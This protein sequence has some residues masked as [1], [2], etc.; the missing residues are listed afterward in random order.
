MPNCEDFINKLLK[1]SPNLTDKEIIA[2]MKELKDDKGKRLYK[3]STIA[4]RLRQLRVEQ[5][6]P[7]KPPEIEKTDED[8]IIDA[9]KFDAPELKNVILD[10]AKKEVE[11]AF[12]KKKE[13]NDEVKKIELQELNSGH[14]KYDGRI[15]PIRQ[16]ID[17][18]I[19]NTGKIPIQQ[20]ATSD[21]IPKD[22]ISDRLDTIIKRIDA[23]DKE[24][25][26]LKQG[27]LPIEDKLVDIQLLESIIDKLDN[28]KAEESQDINETIGHLIERNNEIK[29]MPP[30]FLRKI[31]LDKDGSAH[32]K[33]FMHNGNWK[34]LK[35][36]KPIIYGIAGAVV[37]GL[38]LFALLILLKALGVLPGWI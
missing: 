2:K 35:R 34:F 14:K 36:A 11:D 23:V 32:G 8:V 31:S 15:D 38:S 5:Q 20:R 30:D 17:E 25:L 26:Q 19:S 7:S 22:T 37:G 18:H 9:S 27:G 1:E 10:D 16:E 4:N 28:L 12:G 3:T 13:I 33:L 29:E 21:S 24:I 6:V